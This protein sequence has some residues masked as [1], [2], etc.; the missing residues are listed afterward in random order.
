MDEDVQAIDIFL[1]LHH[2]ILSSSWYGG[3]EG[4]EIHVNGVL[5]ART[6]PSPVK[7]VWDANLSVSDDEEWNGMEWNG[8][9]W[10]GMEWNG[11]ERE[12]TKSIKE[13]SPV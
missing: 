4:A 3:R 9:E 10:N 2:R 5:H 6:D 11:V 12:S 1:L 13:Q 8:M 7:L